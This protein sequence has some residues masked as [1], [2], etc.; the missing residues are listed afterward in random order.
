M[1]IFVKTLTGT[2]RCSY[3]VDHE[4]R[5]VGDD[6]VQERIGG[7]RKQKRKMR[8]GP[9]VLEGMPRLAYVDPFCI[10]HHGI[11]SMLTPCLPYYYYN[12][13]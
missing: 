1:Q 3:F 13:R 8:I 12:Y 11:Y 7:W 10:N 9:A 5:Y 6:G 2:Y 4:D